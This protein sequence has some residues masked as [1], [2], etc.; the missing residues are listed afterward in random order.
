VSRPYAR[1]GESERSGLALLGEVRETASQ[2][3]H[4]V[5]EL[6]CAATFVDPAVELG[7]HLRVKRRPARPATSALAGS[8]HPRRHRCVQL[9][10]QRSEPSSQLLLVL[11]EPLAEATE[12]GVQRM[13]AIAQIDPCREGIRW[14]CS[15]FALDQ[16]EVRQNLGEATLLVMRRSHL[17]PRRGERT[18]GGATIGRPRPPA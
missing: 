2:V 12:F 16:L 9:G 8:T 13:L 4:L 18:I 1:T 3:A 11:A 17:R 6:R 14:Q 7:E 5:G 15:Q 10:L